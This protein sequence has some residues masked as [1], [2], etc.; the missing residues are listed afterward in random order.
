MTSLFFAIFIIQNY[1]STLKKPWLIV[2]IIF[3]SRFLPG[4]QKQYI[5]NL[6]IGVKSYLLFGSNIGDTL[7]IYNSSRENVKGVVSK[8]S[9]IKSTLTPGGPVYEVIEKYGLE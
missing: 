2:A 7:L 4:V 1:F 3:F 6:E 8:F 5:I 9:L